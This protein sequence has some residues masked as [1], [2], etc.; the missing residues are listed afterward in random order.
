MKFNLEKPL[1]EIIFKNKDKI[2]E[3]G[4]IYFSSKA[5]RQYILP[6]GKKI[7]IVTWERM[8][9]EVYLNIIEIK[10]DSISGQNG[11]VQAYEYAAELTDILFRENGIN[12]IYLKVILLGYDSKDLSIT[13]FLTFLPDIY[14]YNACPLDGMKFTQISEGGITLNKYSAIDSMLNNLNLNIVQE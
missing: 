6:S 12:D 13:K 1:E 3:Y 10:K 7:D 8:G 14:T 9:D 4:F 2:H 11:I 5:F